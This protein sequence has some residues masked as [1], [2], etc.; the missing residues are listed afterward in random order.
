M[1]TILGATIIMSVLRVKIISENKDEITILVVAAGEN[2]HDIVMWTVENNWSGLE[3][4]A[5]IPGT[6]GAVVCGNIAAYGQNQGDLV[7]SVEVFDL[8]S[9]KT[10]ILTHDQCEFVYRD[11][12][13]KK[14]IKTNFLVTKVIY[15]LSRLHLLLPHTIPATMNPWKAN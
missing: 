3:N 2:W 13:F 1:Y 8:L 12:A 6:V 4:M 9:K 11:S 5:L 10:E 15:K 14:N 7:H